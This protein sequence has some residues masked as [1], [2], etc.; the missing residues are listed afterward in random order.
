MKILY[1]SYCIPKPNRPEGS[2]IFNRIKE[3]I[4]Q[5]IEV[6]PV[7]SSNLYSSFLSEKKIS[8]VLKNWGKEYNFQQINLPLDLDVFNLKKIEYPNYYLN[9]LFFNNISKI[10]DIFYSAKCNL[11]HAHYIRDGVYAYM[12][13]KKYGIPYVVTAHAYDIHTVPLRSKALLN[14][15]LKVLENSDKSIFVSNTILEQA[16]KF[17]Y[18]AHNA[19][20]IHNGYNPNDFCYVPRQTANKEIITLG[21]VGSLIER[22]RADYLPEILKNVKSK[23]NGIKLYIIG[24]GILKNKI[25]DQFEKYHLLENVSFFGQIAQAQLG[26]YYNEMDVLILPSKNEGFPTVIVEALACGVPIVASDCDGNEEAVHNCGKVVPQDDSFI[27]KFSDAIVDVIKNPISKNLI[28]ERAKYF[29]WQQIVQ[30]EIQIYKQ[31]KLV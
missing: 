6:I 14:L 11:I 30:K 9:L 1:F 12:L 5:Q 17:G 22:K 7:T 18:S 8:L 26:K 4:N 27:E 28:L 25:V 3:L 31:I 21:F 13:K 15:T 20:V 23:I 29:T 10:K 2:F 16:K 19:T 24:Q